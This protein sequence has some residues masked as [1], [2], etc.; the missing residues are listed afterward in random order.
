MAEGVQPVSLV[1][2]GSQRTSNTFCTSPFFYWAF[3]LC[4]SVTDQLVY[5]HSSFLQHSKCFGEHESLYQYN[6]PDSDEWWVRENCQLECV[7]KDICI[8]H[9]GKK[10][11]NSTMAL[12]QPCRGD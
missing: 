10:S 5:S 4:M 11:T 6:S 7:R 8:A 9:T 3:P 12:K 2:T 1:L